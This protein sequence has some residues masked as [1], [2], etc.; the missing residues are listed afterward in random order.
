MATYNGAKYLP[1]Q[2]QSFLDQNRQPDEVI[3]SDDCSTD[4]TVEIC[5]KFANKAPFRVEVIRNENNLG[6]NKNFENAL[7]HC[8]GDIIFISDQDDVWFANKIERVL[9]YFVQHPTAELVIHDLEFCDMN[10][11]PIGQ[12][13]LERISSYKDPME[14]YVTGMAT[15]ITSELKDLCLPLP[16]SDFIN[17]DD[18]LHKCSYILENKL[19]IYEP[20]ALYRRHPN[21]TTNESNLNVP[22]K[23]N[24]FFYLKDEWLR[25]IKRN[26]KES[27]LVAIEKVDDEIV[28]LKKIS[29][30]LKNINQEQYSKVQNFIT[31]LHN[32]KRIVK[33]RLELHVYNRIKRLFHA[34]KFYKKGGYNKFSG[35]RTLIKDIL[36]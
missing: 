21:N 35:L 12:K 13:K 32:E 31:Q 24:R 20:L 6:Y 8:T 1:E 5:Q 15:A 25:G 3:I 7:N 22:F 14:S 30:E 27:G 19:I 4:S 11:N 28:H 2:L 26:V 18:W 10:L 9:K 16:E 29:I 23:T 34:I 36:S 33:E 17:Y